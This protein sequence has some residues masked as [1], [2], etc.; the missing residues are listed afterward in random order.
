MGSLKKK[1]EGEWE[2]SGGCRVFGGIFGW[3]VEGLGLRW[4]GFSRE[5]TSTRHCGRTEV[6]PGLGW[7]GV[8]PAHSEDYTLRVLGGSGHCLPCPQ[9]T[10]TVRCD[11]M[12]SHNSYFTIY[13]ADFM[14]FWKL[15]RGSGSYD[16]SVFGQPRGWVSSVLC[17]LS[18]AVLEKWGRGSGIAGG[19]GVRGEIQEQ[20]EVWT[21][22]DSPEGMATLC[23]ALTNSNHAC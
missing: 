14:H 6:S 11:L 1:G 16:C 9:G 7:W 4:D 21:I 3:G 22:L 12:L 8:H 23:S 20:G 18:R 15:C 13:L 17:H 19:S 10:S 5:A 2:W